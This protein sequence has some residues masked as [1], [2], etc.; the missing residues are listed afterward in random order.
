MDYDISATKL[1]TI[2]Q[3]SLCEGSKLI[4]KEREKHA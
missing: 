4:T 2:K 3:M 1:I